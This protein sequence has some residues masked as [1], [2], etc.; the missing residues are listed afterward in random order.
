MPSGLGRGLA[1]AGR[2]LEELMVALRSVT[3]GL[4][5]CAAARRPLP[6]PGSGVGHPHGVIRGKHGTA[7]HPGRSPRCHHSRRSLRPSAKRHEGRHRERCRLPAHRGGAGR[8]RLRLTGRRLP[9][10]RALGKGELLQ[11]RS[12]CA[13]ASLPTESLGH[14]ARASERPKRAESQHIASPEHGHAHQEGPRGLHQDHNAGHLRAHRLEREP[15]QRVLGPDYEHSVVPDVALPVER[16]RCRHAGMAVLVSW[17]RR[18]RGAGRR[19]ASESP[20]GQVLICRPGGCEG[21]VHGAGSL[22][23]GSLRPARRPTGRR[24]CR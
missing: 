16:D 1:N 2:H 9:G 5:A 15:A 17:G 18:R 12:L 24:C 21:R 20:R 14:C 8:V 22:R 7:H 10:Q 23:A 13:A 6:G 19:C 4:H 11:A 3:K